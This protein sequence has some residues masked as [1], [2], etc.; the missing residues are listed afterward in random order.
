M[1]SKKYIGIEVHRESISLAVRNDAGEIRTKARSRSLVP[2]WTNAGCRV[3]RE[4]SP[5][6]GNV[7]FRNYGIIG[8]VHQLHLVLRMCCQLLQ[9]DDCLL[10]TLGGSAPKDV[11]IGEQFKE[12]VLASSNAPPCYQ[13]THLGNIL[14]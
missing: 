7:S 5:I 10:Q 2:G 1:N 6:L 3:G 13:E 11:A 8:R 14:L 9:F 12:V 4:S